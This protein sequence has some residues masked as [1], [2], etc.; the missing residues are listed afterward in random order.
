MNSVLCNIPHSGLLIPNDMMEDYI[1][2]EKDLDFFSKYMVDKDVDKLFSFVPEENKV[3]SEISRVVVDMERY[4]NDK[5]EIMSKVGMGLF[6]TH[7]TFGKRIRVKGKT[8][9][10]CLELYNNYHSQMAQKT[11]KI[12]ESNR[13]CYILDC[14]SFHDKLMYT[15]FD[16]KLFPDIC[17]GFNGYEVN[18]DIYRI[19]SLCE[20]Y[21]YSVDFNVPFSGSLIPNG[22]NSN[23]CV[24]SIMIELNRRIYCNSVDGFYRVQRMC[25]DIYA[26]LDENQCLI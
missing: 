16:T 18:R 2:L 12:L 23:P 11:A 6:Y 1:I 4:K 10:K 19:K 15:G 25:Q 21:G 17:I 5:Q 24:K 22:Y 3:V 26:T 14:H 20:G 13:F 8:Y 7:D 9:D